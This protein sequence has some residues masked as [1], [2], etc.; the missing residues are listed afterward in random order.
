[1]KLF[2]KYIFPALYGL[3]IYFTIRL[4]HD[5]AV[6]TQFWKRDLA[7]NIFEI[8]CSIL[9]G[10][11][12]IAIFEAL[13][14]F[15]DKGRRH[16]LNYQGIIR[17]LLQLIG[18]NLLL[19]YL[20]LIPM[21]TFTDDGLS[22]VDVADLTIIPTL[23]AIIYYGIAR[24]RSWL[25]AYVDNKVLL[26]KITNEHLE[27]ELKFLKAQ[28]HPHFLF[29]ALNTI[30]FQMDE[31]L[32]GAKRSIEKFSEL[33]R[34]QLYDQ[35]QQVDVILEIDYLQS[36]IELQ[37]VRSTDRLKLSLFFDPQLKEQQVYPLFFLPLIENAFKF[38]GGGY[39]MSIAAEID[40]ENIIFRVEN[41]VPTIKTTESK[42]GGIGLEN[43]K[44]RLN[45][46]YPDRHLL[47]IKQEN[48]QFK[49]MLKLRYER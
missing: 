13:F 48:D 44:R 15:Y 30:Y 24:S 33:L 5:L 20:I 22:W 17:E 41:D 32:P 1:M 23:Y 2:K 12:S 46:V 25:K 4:L 40:D 11:L 3:L 37:K 9:L 42:T 26:E 14:R 6:D 45:L 18:V 8:L 16:H 21:A 47:D 49:V 38:V 39:Q 43:L 35:Q 7:L 27:T 28:Y 36:F 10:Y 19:T 29:N 31:D 34:Y